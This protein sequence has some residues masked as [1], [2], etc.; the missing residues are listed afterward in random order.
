MDPVPSKQVDAEAQ[1]AGVAR[2][3]LRRAK[4][5]LGIKSYKDG[6]KGGWF[7]ALPKAL[8]NIEDAHLKDVSTF[9]TDEHLR[10]ATKAS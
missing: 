8:K 7:C 2:A 1:E 4:A 3:T 10:E 5:S 6:L 9:G